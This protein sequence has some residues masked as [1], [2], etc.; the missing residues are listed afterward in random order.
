MVAGADL[1][2]DLW[3]LNSP[4]STETFCLPT[5]LPSG[6]GHHTVNMGG[7]A[8]WPNVLI[9]VTAGVLHKQNMRGDPVLSQ[10]VSGSKPSTR[11]GKNTEEH[12]RKNVLQPDRPKTKVCLA[13]S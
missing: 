8:M 1:L 4:V 2:F 7:A 11:V 10:K 12:V 3:P 5:P 13:V 6:V 9:C